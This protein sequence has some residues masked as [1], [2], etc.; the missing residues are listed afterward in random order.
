M[1]QPL[2]LTQCFVSYSAK[3]VFLVLTGFL[4]LGMNPSTSFAS[5]T[6]ATISGTP[7]V[8]NALGDGGVGGAAVTT[9]G[10]L[11]VVGDSGVSSS[12]S[13][14]GGKGGDATGATGN[15]GAGGDAALTVSGAVSASS[16]N[17]TV[18]GGDGGTSVGGVGGNGGNASVSIGPMSIDGGYLIVLGGNGG[19]VGNASASA[20]SLTMDS[21]LARV[22]GTSA[23]ASLGSLTMGDTSYLLVMGGS[24]GTG[25]LTVTGS[26][27]LGN[28]MGPGTANVYGKDS[29]F[30]VGSNLSLVNASYLG[31]NGGSDGSGSLVAASSVS[32]NG[33]G[34]NV[35]GGNASM[36][37]GSDLDVVDGASMNVSSGSAGS[38][39]L[40]VEHDM[41]VGDA[42]QYGTVNITGKDA[43]VS[44]GSDLSVINRS[45]VNLTGGM[46]GVGSLSATGLV[47]LD[48]SS[49]NMQGGTASVASGSFTASNASTLQVY[50]WDTGV[51]SWTA[52]GSMAVD[53]S[54]VNVIGLN[55]S[56]SAG[57]FTAGNSSILGVT[58]GDGGMASLGVTGGM[59]LA[60]SS[61]NVTGGNALASADTLTASD[62]ATLSLVAGNTGT[63]SLGTSGAVSMNAASLNVTGGIASA[64]IGSLALASGSDWRL[65]SQQ[66]GSSLAAAGSALLDH[67]SVRLVGQT[68]ASVSAVTLVLVNDSIMN[69][70][71]NSGSSV[72]AAAV[73]VANSSVNVTGGTASVSIGQLTLADS[74]SSFTVGGATNTSARLGGLFG[75]GSL[76]VTGGPS[77]L[78]VTNGDFSGTI[79]GA[80][81]LEKVGGA[82][83]TLVLNGNNVYSN[84]TTVAGGILAVDTH[85]TLGTSNLVTVGGA[86]T[87]DFIHGADADSLVV[88]NNGK[89]FFNDTA[90]AGSAAVTGGSGSTLYFAGSAQGGN[91]AFHQAIGSIFDISRS[92]NGVTVGSVDGGGDLYLGGKNLGL[93]INNA[94]MALS[95]TLQDG[96][97]NGGTGGSL[98]KLGSGALT[99][100]G[101]NTYT[102]GTVLQDGRLVAASVGALG[103]GGV[104]L[105]G[106]SLSADAGIHVIMV[107]TDYL[108]KAPAVLNLR[109]AGI[110]TAGDILWVGGTA[111]LGGTLHLALSGSSPNIGDSFA[112][113]SADSVTGRFASV[114]DDLTDRRFLAVYLPDGVMVETLPGSFQQLSSSPN[115][116]SVAGALDRLFN[117]PSQVSLLLSLGALTADEYDKAYELMNPSGLASI[118]EVQYRIAELQGS[119]LS[120]RMSDFL[121]KRN[122]F[123]DRIASIDGVRFAGTQGADEEMATAMDEVSK[124]SS[125]LS[126]RWG[127]FYCGDVGNLKV[128]GGG[129]GEGY[130]ATFRGMTAA[131]ADFRVCRNLAVGFLFGYQ[132]AD[133]NT[134]TGSHVDITGGQLG[135]YGL[136]KSHDFYAQALVEGGGNSYDSKRLSYG[137]AE[138]GAMATGTTDGKLI[139]GQLGWG[140]QYTSGSWA[141]GPTAS[142]QYTRLKMSA[143][144][145]TGSLTPEFFPSQAEYSLSVRWGAQ[146][147]G[148][149]NLG[150]NLAL[151]PTL[152]GSWLEEFH[153]KG[154]SVTSSIAGQVFTVDG[155]KIGQN[156]F[157][158]E[159]SLGIE[160]KK[161]ADLSVRYQKD[162]GRDD[163]NAQ[164]VGVEL[165]YKL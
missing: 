99:L 125:N 161:A 154:G 29:T 79:S 113:V 77:T 69:L 6:D 164:T 83:D 111:S 31:V 41:Q 43:S 7:G 13:V 121:S 47:S 85:G 2:T 75:S 76:T 162:L 119:A 92:A 155:A 116:G 134:D 38:S 84:A 123:E 91:A 102:G 112:V 163:F 146:A 5:A 11:D 120:G 108:Q 48:S 70:S 151:I 36:S 26:M 35:L 16:G 110:H 44:V 52:L 140:Y 39:S 128:D 157:R 71:S 130:K 152:A 82:A 93:G 104:T 148:D 153:D 115:Q 19:T 1:K 144:Q 95:G 22:S 4:C 54:D 114:A 117:D 15:G 25:S 118:F 149:F 20:S 165:R 74:S 27:Q 57:S 14:L 33:G 8:D 3:I 81:G 129:N 28:G 156:D 101:T 142:F 24:T 139:S 160:W 137:T 32:M 96:G 62:A 30:F 73:S 67:S 53:G 17:V 158:V 159:A 100:S 12:Y 138:T 136:V 147:S 103:S 105:N 150:R 106:G 133:V 51:A 9:V 141:V 87:L 37:T 40:R 78:Q 45:A 23:S 109:A 132:D 65:T 90:T 61:V 68:T 86:G 127:G 126:E 107:E 18:A 55:A 97:V 94:D 21:S 124:T 80:V 10:I 143:F 50:A 60:G 42:V 131:G 122:G 135:V 89:V 66:G 46:D 64:S 56:V 49:V 59:T 72:A 98:T 63:A 34:L 88:F 58:A 145:E